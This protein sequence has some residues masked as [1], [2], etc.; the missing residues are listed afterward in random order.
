MTFFGFFVAFITLISIFTGYKIYEKVLNKSEDKKRESIAEKI[1]V[2]FFV[3]LL[4][5]GINIMTFV[6][7]YTFI[8]EKT[9]RAYYEPRYEATV[10]GY[11]K[12][13]VKTQSFGKSSYY[14]RP[15]YFPKV[16]YT[17]ENGVKVFKTLDF[18]TNTPL[19]TGEKVKITDTSSRTSANALD[20]DPIM[21][22]FAGV[23]TGVAAFFT[24]LLSTYITVFALKKR[25]R[26]SIY[27]ALGIMIVNGVCI[28][29]LYLKM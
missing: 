13:L 29:L 27:F 28:G 19:K 17:D 6:S 9:Y 10:I 5:T 11:K 24:S 14:D 12:E 7:S 16:V 3:S 21:L 15:V 23:F 1:V 18:T 2:L 26:I 22:L 25:I 8:W 20:I 4:M